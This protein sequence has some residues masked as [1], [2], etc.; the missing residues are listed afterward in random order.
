[1]ILY[2]NVVGYMGKWYYCKNGQQ[3][4]PVG[5]DELTGFIE[6]GELSVDDRVWKVGTP[7]WLRIYKHPELVEALPSVLETAPHHTAVAAKPKSILASMLAA[8][9]KRRRDS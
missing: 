8:L 2:I 9:G 4:G 5:L 7:E 1:L 3:L 6:R